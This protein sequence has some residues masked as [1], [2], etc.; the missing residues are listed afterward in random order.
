MKLAEAQAFLAPIARGGASR[1]DAFVHQGLVDAYWEA[2]EPQRQRIRD[3]AEVVLYEGDDFERGM[4]ADF[5]V[6][7]MAP[8]DVVA[9]AVDQ[10]QRSGDARVAQVIER[11]W[12]ITDASTTARLRTLFLRDPVRHM[13]VGKA[14]LYAD[15]RGEP[16]QALERAVRG[17]RDVELLYQAFGVAFA[18]NRE[19]DF[20]ELMRGKPAEVVRAV[21]E[22]MTPELKAKLLSVASS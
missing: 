22:R 1:N 7:I 5:F 21:A 3:A 20:V 12:P 8:A 13:G 2:D 17:S 4:V 6:T 15:A 9:R 19:S 14:V 10:Y 18:A 16:W 11:S